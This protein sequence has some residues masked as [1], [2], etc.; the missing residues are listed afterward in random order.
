VNGQLFSLDL[1]S[2]LI[3]A[4]AS[5]RRQQFLQELGL[6][7]TVMTSPTREDKP[8]HGED[9]QSYTARAARD[10]AQ[11]VVSLIPK[12]ETPLILAADTVVSINGHILGKPRDNDEALA[13]LQLLAGQRHQVTTSVCV[14]LP[15]KHNNLSFAF[16]D[17]ASVTFYPWSRQVL[18]AYVR[19]GEPLDK[20][21]AYAVQGKGAFLIQALQGAWT[22]VVGLPVGRLCQEL[23]ARHLI[24]A[25]EAKDT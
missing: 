25:Q 13:M 19:S 16:S 8:K 20:A 3:L 6:P 21:G 11:A 15:G 7:Y 1:A 12:A 22:T 9:A 18:E 10:K 5:P 4:S 23:L 17:E 2:D 24:A 14:L